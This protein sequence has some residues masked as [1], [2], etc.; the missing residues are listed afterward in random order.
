MTL[1]YFLFDYYPS[2]AIIYYKGRS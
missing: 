1:A 2:N